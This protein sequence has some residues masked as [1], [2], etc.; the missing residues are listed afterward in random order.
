MPERIYMKKETRTPTSIPSRPLGSYRGKT[1]PRRYG[2]YGTQRRVGCGPRG[3]R[4]VKP[5]RSIARS[6]PTRQP[7]EKPVR[8]GRRAHVERLL[9]IGDGV[10]SCQPK[11]PQRGVDGRWPTSPR[12]RST[13]LAPIT[14]CS[15]NRGGSQHSL[16]ATCSP[17]GCHLQVGRAREVARGRLQP[18]VVSGRPVVGKQ[19]RELGR[20]GVV[21]HRE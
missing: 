11:P 13:G 4:C 6:E 8:V 15:T 7:E 17:S 5:R 3:R 18:L 12:R 1:S 10:A 16:R 9:V 20:R 2:T 19:R 21:E 14:R